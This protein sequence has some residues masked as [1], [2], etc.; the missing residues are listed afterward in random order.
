MKKYPVIVVILLV[1]VLLSVM[2][3]TKREDF[4]QTF[5]VD[6]VTEEEIKDELIIAIFIDSIRKCA[7]DYY[8]EFYAGQIAIY[9]YETVILETEKTRNGFI[10]I[11]FGVTPMIGAHNP[12]GYDELLFSVDS[13]GHGQL[14]TYE[15]IKD[16]T[17][18]ERFEQYIINIA[19]LM[20]TVM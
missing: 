5:S 3:W 2:C 1:L 14:I 17:I 4:V 10:N 20:L 9:N 11:K 8:S 19:C 13:A 18:P 16:Y 7:V 15:H 12:L 6:A